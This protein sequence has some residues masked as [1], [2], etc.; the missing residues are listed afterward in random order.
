MVTKGDLEANNRVLGTIF[1]V[2]LAETNKRIDAIAQDTKELKKGQERLEQKLDKAVQN[3][4]ERIEI[5]EEHLG[6]PHKN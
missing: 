1:R 4:E 6:L 5:I 2:E 3:R